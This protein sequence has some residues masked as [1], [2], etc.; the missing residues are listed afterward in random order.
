MHR[1]K[2]GKIFHKMNE[3]PVQYAVL[4][5]LANLSAVVFVLQHIKN[6]IKFAPLT[7]ATSFIKS[8]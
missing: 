5:K 7:M 8:C 1:S 4:E 3:L 2:A 6:D